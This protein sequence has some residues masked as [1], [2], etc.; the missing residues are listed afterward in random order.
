LR[1]DLAGLYLKLKAYDDCKRV[2]IEALKSIQSKK[3]DIDILV[4]NVDTLMLLS[5]VYLEEDMQQTDWKFKAN[6]DAK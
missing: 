5:K 2:L 6:P 4:K 3:K 1:I